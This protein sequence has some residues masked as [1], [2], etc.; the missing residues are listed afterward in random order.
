MEQWWEQNEKAI[1]ENY[2]QNEIK[3]FKDEVEDLTG[4][5]PLLLDKCIING[6]IDLSAEAFVN[7]FDQ[8]QRFHD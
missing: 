2:T 5:I 7:V 1:P 3:D 8:V 4:S 6:K